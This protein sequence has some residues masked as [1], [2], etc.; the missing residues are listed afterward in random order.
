MPSGTFL[1]RLTEG[2]REETMEIEWSE[3]D[4][5]II[6]QALDKVSVQGVAAMRTVLTTTAKV[7][8]ALKSLEARRTAEAAIEDG[9]KNKKG[10]KPEDD[11]EE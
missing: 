7:E 4:L 9:E 6:L 2:M 1:A 10:E 3:Q 5:G 8:A 11:A